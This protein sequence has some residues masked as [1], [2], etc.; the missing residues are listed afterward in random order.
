MNE[1]RIRQIFQVS[2]ILKGLHAAIE[3]GGGV[4]LYFVSTATV[5]RCV[6]SLTQ[7]ELAE[8]PRDFVARHLL[9][10]AHHLSVV[11][12]TFYAFYL[13]S[14][15]LINALLVVGLLKEKLWAYPVS[16]V[17]LSGFIAYQIYRFSFYHSFGLVLLTALDILLIAL[18]WHEWRV[19]RK[20]FGNQVAHPGRKSR[21]E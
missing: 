3:C 6:G 2:L 12:E 5:A 14:H 20:H 8:D 19:V 17:V 21:F 13:V 1:R 18:V 11:T 4:V 7:Q 10:A 15:G 16:L 9:N